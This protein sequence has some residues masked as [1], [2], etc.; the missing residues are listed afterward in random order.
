MCAVICAMAGAGGPASTVPVEAV[1]H[2]PAA[3]AMA[4]N[5]QAEYLKIVFMPV[6]PMQYSIPDILPYLL[7]SR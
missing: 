6:R 3:R 7:S 5:K 1:A 4:N 2:G